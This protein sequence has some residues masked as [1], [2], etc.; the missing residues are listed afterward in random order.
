MAKLRDEPG[1]PPPHNFAQLLF[2]DMPFGTTNL[3]RDRYP[4]R[5]GIRMILVTHGRPVGVAL[6]QVTENG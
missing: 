6:P 2:W 5:Y 4:E 3:S 1:K